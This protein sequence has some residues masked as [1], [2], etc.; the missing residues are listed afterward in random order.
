MEDY[1]IPIVFFRPKSG[2]LKGK[3]D[4]IASQIDILPSVMSLLHYPQPYYSLG[5]SLFEQTTKRYSINYNGNIYTYI[6][7]DYCYQFNGENPVSLYRWPEDTLCRNNLYSGIP[8]AILMARDTTLRK[9]LQQYSGDM[10]GNRMTY[11][12]I[13][14]SDK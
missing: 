11:E 13:R 6:D 4:I 8:D 9:M 7:K 14:K 3:S 10:T 12:A 1:R 5:T 2:G